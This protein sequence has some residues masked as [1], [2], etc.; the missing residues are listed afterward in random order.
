MGPSPAY[1]SRGAK[2]PRPSH[3][4]RRLCLLKGCNACFI[5]LQPSQ[6]YCCDSC[7]AA[8]RRW[9]QRRANRRY[10]Q[11]DRGKA[12]RREQARRRRQRNRPPKRAPC[13]TTSS[14]QA[15]SCHATREQ[16]Q[17]C[18]AARSSAP[19]TPRVGYH[20]RDAGKKFSCPRPGCYECFDEDPRSPLKTFCSCLCRQALRRVQRREE[21]WNW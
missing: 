15:Q 18:Q 11:S 7:H 6:R 12:N 21:R 5:P 19:I 10:R 13:Q 3:P 16:G 9:A 17:P 2:Q 8:A 20:Q 4:R 14:C 1:S